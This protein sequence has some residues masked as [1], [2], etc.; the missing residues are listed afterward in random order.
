M[1]HDFG[2]GTARA[3]CEPARPQ[4]L[5]GRAAAADSRV[6]V[7]KDRGISGCIAITRPQASP[8]APARATPPLSTAPGPASRAG[9]FTE[10]LSHLSGTRLHAFV[11]ARPSIMFEHVK[12]ACQHRPPIMDKPPRLP[13]PLGRDSTVRHCIFLSLRSITG[14][15]AFADHLAGMTKVGEGPIRRSPA[16]VR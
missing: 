9:S 10:P 7:I 2:M 6:L 13:I 4:L 11:I 16:L 1:R 8:S 5:I 14:A 3:K 15:A 12:V